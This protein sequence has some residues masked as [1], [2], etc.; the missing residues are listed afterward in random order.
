MH[1][2]SSKQLVISKTSKEEKPDYI[3]NTKPTI[4]S[5]CAVC[6]FNSCRQTLE[7]ISSRAIVLLNNQHFVLLHTELGIKEVL[8]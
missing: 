2:H 5:A 6:N 4:V 8:V 7:L 1:S 3:I